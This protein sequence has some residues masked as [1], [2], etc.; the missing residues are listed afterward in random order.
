MPIRESFQTM[1]PAPIPRAGFVPGSQSQCAR[2]RRRAAVVQLVTG[3]ALVASL[4]VAVSVVLIDIARAAPSPPVPVDAG[5]AIAAFFAVMATGLAG[6][7]AIAF[8][9][10]RARRA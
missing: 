2:S 5:T 10:R 4:A 8:H 7:A 1:R 9:E 6:L 3:S